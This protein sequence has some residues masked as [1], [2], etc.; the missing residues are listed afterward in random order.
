MANSGYSVVPN[1][2]PDTAGEV[3]KKNYTDGNAHVTVK[4]KDNEP[5]SWFTPFD[6]TAAA[7]TSGTVIHNSGDVSIYDLMEFELKVAPAGGEVSAY[8]SHDGV[9][10]FGPVHV[11]S[12]SVSVGSGSQSIVAITALGAYYIMGRFKEIE[13][14]Q[15]TADATVL[16]RV[17]G[18]HSSGNAR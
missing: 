5:Q 18:S 4:S 14:R 15:T 2:I 17:V 13:L 12:R 1:A 9:N 8:V 7:L 3:V 11:V 6:K 16:P 10:F